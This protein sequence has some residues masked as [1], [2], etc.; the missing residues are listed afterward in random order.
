MGQHQRYYY[1]SEQPYFLDPPT[2]AASTKVSAYEGSLNT[3]PVW[4]RTTLEAG[5]R[6]T[7]RRSLLRHLGGR[8]GREHR[9]GQEL[10]EQPVWLGMS[11]PF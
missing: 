8:G 6:Y 5:Y 11:Y 9:R 1:T 2:P 10:P 3:K 7:K 4:G